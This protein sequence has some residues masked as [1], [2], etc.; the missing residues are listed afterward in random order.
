MAIITISRGCYSHGKEIAER[1]AARL[2]YEC[3]S[4]EILIEASNFFNV[5]EIG[6]LNSIEKEPSILE[7]ITRGREKYLTYIKAALLEHAA[8]G[9][10]VYH[11]HAGHL[12]LKE[13]PCVLKV[14]IVAAMENRI[15]FLVKNEEISETEAEKRIRTEDHKRYNWTRYIYNRDIHDIGLYDLVLNIGTI[16]INDACDL[17]CNAAQSKTFAA[18]S[19]EYSQSLKDL[20]ISTHVQA[21][22]KELYDAEVTCKSGIVFIKVAAPRIRK[23]DYATP[24]MQSEIQDQVHAEMVREIAEIARNVP[25]VKDVVCDIDLPYYT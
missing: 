21:A 20:A 8:D 15:Q 1:V 24:H 5:S 12:L 7:R 10:I 18:L 11:G 13:I 9:N 23:S 22:L 16:D 17:I 19:A 25:A 6:L 14:R 4:R 2:N 3:I